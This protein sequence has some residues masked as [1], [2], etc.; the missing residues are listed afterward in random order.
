MAHKWIV[1]PLAR[2]SFTLKTLLMM[3]LPRLSNTRTFQMG[4][5]FS[6]SRDVACGLLG[7]SMVGTEADIS[8][9]LRLN[10]RS[11]APGN[12]AHDHD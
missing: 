3:S 4:S 12:S 1:T 11:I 6:P 2:K 7:A 10:I 5:P 8:S 9:L